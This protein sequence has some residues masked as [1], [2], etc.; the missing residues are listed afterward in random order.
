MSGAT[1]VSDGLEEE[2]HPHDESTP[3]PPE[4]AAEQESAAT[5]RRGWPYWLALGVLVLGLIVTGVLAAVS[6]SQYSNNENRLLDLR[7]KE[8]GSVLTEALPAIQIPLA[9]AAALADATNGNSAKFTH[10]ASQYVG[11]KREFVS[12]SLWR[13]GPGNM[14]PLTVLGAQPAIATSPTEAQRFFA[15]AAQT[16]QLSIVGLRPPNLTRLGFVFTTSTSSGRFITYAET[17]LPPSRRST[18]QSNSAFSDLDYAVYLGDAQRSADLLVTSVRNLPITGRQA[19]LAIPFGNRKLTLVVSAR[20]PL[21]GTLPQRLPWIIA[22][23]GALLSLGAAILTARLIQGRRSA[24]HLAVRLEDAV[25]ENQRL[26]DEQ[27]TIAQTLQHALLPAGLPSPAG[28]ETGAR[29]EPGVQGVEIG[30][31]WYDILPVDEDRL[32]V[33]V[34]DVSGRGLPAAATMAAL[35]FGIHAY[36]AQGDSPATILQ[37]LAG[38]LDVTTSG[39]F[40]TVMCAL[41]D[42]HSREVTVASAGHLPPL[43]LSHDGAEYLEGEVGVPIGV[44]GEMPYGSTTTTVP[45]GSTLLAYTDGLVER[46]GEHLDRG[47]ARLR[48][49]TIGH[50]GDLSDLLDSLLREV[51]L[52]VSEDDTAIVGVRWK[53]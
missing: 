40:A 9:G 48:E 37:K 47:L 24:E 30:G 52:E 21:A 49:V 3:G 42:V 10:Y 44:H 34:G 41:V 18:L 36:A 15:A 45:P 8:L 1:T 38:L 22:I 33:V 7:V 32:L 31:D 53:E 13:L 5:T 27:R 29:F 28:M 35:R 19:V 4:P 14:R 26:Y 50:D 6:Q 39:Q 46:R 16:H 25:R 2:A 11:P 23:V 12:L 17:M 51:R 20:Q 43:V